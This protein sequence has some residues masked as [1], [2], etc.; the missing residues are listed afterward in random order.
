MGNKT[1]AELIL[2]LIINA[3]IISVIIKN[4]NQDPVIC[5]IKGIL[6]AISAINILR[7]SWFLI[8]KA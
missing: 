5:A 6:I 2:R 1:N 8:K 7:A 4:G 3:I